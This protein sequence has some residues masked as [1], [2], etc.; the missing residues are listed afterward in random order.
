VR[1]G[2]AW[3]GRPLL[4]SRSLNVLRWAHALD[5]STNIKVSGELAAHDTIG[6]LVVHNI[7][8]NMIGMNISNKSS[9]RDESRLPRGFANDSANPWNVAVRRT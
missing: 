4:V 3:F 5:Y 8:N 7:W 1:R 6:L 9:Y 2:V